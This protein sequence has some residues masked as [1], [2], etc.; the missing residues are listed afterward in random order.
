[1]LTCTFEDGGKAH[2]RHTVVDVIVVDNGRILLIKR[3]TKLNEG[4]KWGLP[5]GYVDP[6]ETTLQA[7][8]REV[9]EET[10]WQAADLRL[11]TI[12]DSPRR[13][14]DPR[15]NICFIFCGKAVQKVQ[16]TDWEVDDVQWYPIDQ[17]PAEVEMA[18]DH[19]AL[20]QLYRRY[21]EENLALPIV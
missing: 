14:N 11:F 9:R 4:G 5:G 19:A 17:T 2:L 18:F 7:A 12:I 13:R 21:L 8:T 1:M 15:Q 20:I 6:D 10:G 16:D 3:S